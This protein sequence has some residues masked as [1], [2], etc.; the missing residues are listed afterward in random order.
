MLSSSDSLL[1]SAFVQ[2]MFLDK[3][4]TIT[5]LASSSQF[6]QAKN[7]EKDFLKQKNTTKLQNKN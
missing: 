1:F 5:A 6:L 2:T 3:I 4:D 7:K